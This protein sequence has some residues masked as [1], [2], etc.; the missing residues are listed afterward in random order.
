MSREKLNNLRNKEE[1]YATATTWVE[2]N[3][4]PQEHSQ[5]NPNQKL[6]I[7]SGNGAV[8]G[9]DIMEA[10]WAD[11]VLT[12]LPS[13]VTKAPPNWGTMAWGKLSAK[14]W[15]VICTIHLPI[16]LIRLWGGD[17]LPN[18]WKATLENFMDLVCAVQIVNLRSVSRKEVE[19]YEHYIFCY[20]TSFK[21]LYKLAKVKP[22]HHAALHYGDV[23]RGFGPAHTHSATFYEW[24]IH[25]MQSVN[26]NM[27]LEDGKYAF[28]LISSSAEVYNNILAEDIHGTRLAHMIDMVHLTQQ[29]PDFAY[30]RDSVHESSLPNS[31]LAGFIQFLKFKHPGPRIVDTTEGSSSE[32]AP[33]KTKFLTLNKV[34]LRGVQYSTTTSQAHDSH[35]FFRPPQLE[36][37]KPQPC[38]E[39]GQITHIFL[40]SHIPSQSHHL[41]V[42]LC[43]RPYA[44]LQPSPE[45]NKV[46]QMYRQFGFA[47]GFLHQKEFVPSVI[48]EP[49]NVISHVA[50]TPLCISGHE[51]A[52]ILPMDK[53]MQMLFMHTEDINVDD[54]VGE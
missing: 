45:L 50:V 39:P 44:P 43:V 29:T 1:L 23:L 49:S 16:T 8:L 53:L 36:M 33:P 17:D 22:I 9:K 25:S 3:V 51:V 12:K 26:H 2:A 13:W 41:S 19:L 28:S 48:I 30:N 40:H 42:Y 32:F 52:H 4:L 27:K 20:M 14:N 35:V 24:H 5:V 10:V 47:G 6:K 34:S 46:D 15:R 18:D 7:P 37:S 54:P 31:I 11:M 38:P 21:S